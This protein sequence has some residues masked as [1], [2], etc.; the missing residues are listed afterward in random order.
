MDPSKW[1]VRKITALLIGIFLVGSASASQYFTASNTITDEIDIAPSDDRIPLQVGYVNGEE[2]GGEN[3]TLQEGEWENFGIKLT[4]NS[5]K[6]AV[7]WENVFIRVKFYGVRE[8]YIRGKYQQD[9]T[10]RTLRST[11]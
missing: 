3:K 6:N 1:G 5:P 8:E 10:G 11:T 2:L 9:S 4:N 7:P